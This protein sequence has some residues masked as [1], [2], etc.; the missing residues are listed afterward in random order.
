MEN[1]LNPDENGDR[2][3]HQSS[4]DPNDNSTSE[5]PVSLT[6]SMD[7]FVYPRT[8]SES[9]SGFSDQIDE[10]SSSCSEPSPSD[11]PV[12]TE[13]KS[14]K[15]LTTGLELQT[16]EIREAQE[17]SEPELETMKERFA[18]LLL[19]EDMS[20]SGKGVC[21]AVTI[22][23]AIT[24]LYATVFGQNLRLEPLETE[25]RA[26]W[27]REMN[28]LLSVCDYI[29]EFIPR[30]QSLSNGT[31]V[32][33]MESRPRADIYI[34]LPALRKLDSMLMVHHLIIQRLIH[35]NY[36]SKDLLLLMIF[37]FLFL[38]QEVLDGFQDTEFWYAEE[39]SLSMKSA[40]SAT[41]SFRKVIVQRK[42]EK[43]WLPVP[44]VPPE[45]LSDKARKQLKNKR[46]ST[47][48]I[49][50]AAMAINSSILSE[51]E[52]PES[53][54][55]TL[56]KCGK[57]SVGDS[58][59]RYMSG[60][61]R[62]FPEKLLDCLNIASEH[63]AVQLADRV[64]ASM[65]TW[66]RKACLSNS[67]NSWNMVKDL[68]ST[69]ERTDK[70]YVMA[71][72]AETLLFCLKQRYPE[73]SQTSLDICKIQYNKDVGKA[74]LESY[75]RVLEGL[76]FNIVAWIDDVLYVDKTMSGSE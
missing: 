63:E 43:W 13:S 49:H 2:V 1:V 25:K 12:L 50:K 66:R 18:K 56:P 32:E 62:F 44:L 37:V 57:S 28:C 10:T 52:I 53:Y 74:V 47:N 51:M 19:G 21:T 26:L 35:K 67:K 59:Y 60:S 69:T 5:T 40:R 27:K 15:C 20:G 8:C 30:C 75:S 29:V 71:E 34:N 22:S 70:N 17:I 36:E 38:K 3:Y 76:A 45:G 64:E 61:G 68:M 9:T 4:I 33:V 48:Q 41:G 24:N 31:T 23:N 46:E 42:E 16:N 14:S 6:M 39:G 73:L 58:I 55:A 72:R 54:M 7:S 11:W 65:Y